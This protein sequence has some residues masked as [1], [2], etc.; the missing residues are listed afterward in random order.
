MAERQQILLIYSSGILAFGIYFLLLSLFFLSFLSSRIQY[1]T[2]S[3]A[4]LEQSISI[5]LSEAVKKKSK[6]TKTA[7]TP[8]EGLGVKDLF[9]SI[10]DENLAPQ[11]NGD[12]RSEVA[13]NTK[14]KSNESQIKNIQEQLHRISNDLK[15]L[16]AKTLDIKSTAVSPELTSGQYNKWFAE[17]YDIIYGKWQVNFYQTAKATVL[18]QVDKNGRFVHKVVRL[19]QYDDF[20]QSVL[21]F[22]ES[23]KGEKFPPP[24]NGKAISIEVNLLTKE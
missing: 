10:P 21:D 8:L 2:K 1:T 17:I 24:P 6:I 7:G 22:L 23:F 11:V 18:L 20:N 3:N 14:D 12:N 13:K 19:S 16:Q 4:V 9:A 5:V 15:T